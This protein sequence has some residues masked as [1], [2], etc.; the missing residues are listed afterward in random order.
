MNAATSSSKP[1]SEAV[2]AEAAA[3]IARLHGSDRT[4]ADES[5]FR[6]WL[7]A[8]PE[9]AAAFE[10]MTELWEAGARLKS[11]A[12]SRA[13]SQPRHRSWAPAALAATLLIVVAAGAMFLMRS[14]AE[15]TRIGE[16]RILALEDGTRVTLNTATRLEVRYDK[17]QRNIVLK[18]GEALFEVARQPGRPF[19]VT[20]GG[21]KV[22]ALGTSFVVRQDDARLSVIL[23]DGKV[24][25]SR[26]DN[27]SG[28]SENIVMTPGQRLTFA[29]AQPP[30]LDLPRLDKV[31]AWRQGQI[32]LDDMPLADAIAEMNRYSPV[33]LIVE[34]GA[35]D[36]V[37]V[38]GAFRA[39]DNAEFAR[40]LSRTHGLQLKEEP[41]RIVLSGAALDR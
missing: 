21:R 13:P 32:A 34:G 27:D 33:R 5:S 14:G 28:E 31:T 10:R 15:T 22:T 8:K 38:S 29:P 39:G 36:R 20:A 6:R 40:A 37:R 9:H 30:A 19:V 41:H 24:S 12:L 18:T 23:V 2:R 17:N 11:T 1:A 16:Q 35:V 7:A 25:I 26:E 4:A 3:W